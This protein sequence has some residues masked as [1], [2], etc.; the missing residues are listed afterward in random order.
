VKEGR[1]ILND[2]RKMESL[3]TCDECG[4]TFNI[5]H[6]AAMVDKKKVPRQIKE[7]QS[8]LRGEHVDD[9][10]LRHLESYELD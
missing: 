4:A 8:I 7:V 5:T 9:N 6:H 2:F 3:A 1:N 10:F